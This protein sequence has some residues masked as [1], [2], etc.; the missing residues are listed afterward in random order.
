MRE[1]FFRIQDS[2]NSL[3]VLREQTF[4][5]KS[6][7]CFLRINRPIMLRELQA[8]IF[9]TN[10]FSIF[11]DS[12]W[13]VYT[14]NPQNMQLK[15][16]VGSLGCA[17]SWPTHLLLFYHLQHMI[18][19]LKIIS[20]PKNNSCSSHYVEFWDWHWKETGQDKR[21]LLSFME[22]SAYIASKKT[23]TSLCSGYNSTQEKSKLLVKKLRRRTR[24]GS[25]SNLVNI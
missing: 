4:S 16:E 12:S 17:V 18:F 3:Y 24:G 20:R 11:L 6:Q 5:C 9:Q 15:E 22:T 21:P 19:I 25:P 7:Q 13:A 10:L 2:K 1:H 23:G 8:L 14:K